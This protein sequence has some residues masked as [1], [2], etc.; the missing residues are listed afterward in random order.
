M[1]LE[2]YIVSTMLTGLSRGK[3]WIA[4]YFCRTATR[5][6]SYISISS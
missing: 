5:G 2:I 6:G 3:S 4:F 1:A